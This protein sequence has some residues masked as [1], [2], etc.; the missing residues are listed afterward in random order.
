MKKI[1]PLE[2]LLFVINYSLFSQTGTTL[3]PVATQ[4][5]ENVKTK[6]SVQEKNQIAAG[7]GFILSGNE[8]EP[9]AHDKDSKEYP[10]AAMVSPTDLN[11][12]GKE[13]IF[14]I[15][16]N[17]FTS[18]HAGSSVSVF[19]SNSTGNYTQ[20]L[21]FPGTSPDVLQTFNQ[22]Y[23]DLLIGGPGFEYPVW[24]WNGKEYALSRKVRDSDYEKLRKK[25]IG[26]L[27][28]AYQSTMR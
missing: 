26:E 8:R 28:K 3:N 6:L 27:S 5:F 1:L 23:P 20:N 13:E 16:G 10:F 15:Y 2:V 19:I 24:R 7:L 4:L 11:G 18:G 25:S 17:S 22:G 21:G 12:D 14:I 9:F